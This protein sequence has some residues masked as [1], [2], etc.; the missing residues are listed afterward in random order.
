MFHLQ[1]TPN[2]SFFFFGSV[3][4]GIWKHYWSFIFDSTPFIPNLVVCT[5]IGIAHTYINQHNV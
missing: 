5:I 2:F 1:T 4:E 3:L